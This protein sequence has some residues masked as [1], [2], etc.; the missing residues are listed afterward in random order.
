MQESIQLVIESLPYLLKGAVFT[1]QLSIGGM[2]L[3][4]CWDLC[5][6]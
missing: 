6:R 4:C 5:W 1:L 3:V 2:F